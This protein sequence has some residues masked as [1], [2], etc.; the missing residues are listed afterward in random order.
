MPKASRSARARAAFPA[1][2]VMP[3]T[4][5]DIKVQAVRRPWRAKSCCTATTLI[6]AHEH[7][8]QLA[9]ERGL[10]FVHPF[11]DVDVIAGQGTIGMEILR[12]QHGDE[13]DAIFVPI[14][15]GGLIAR[16]CG[17]RQ[18]ALSDAS[19]SSASSP[20]TAAGMHESLRA[21]KR[22]TLDRVG[23]FADG[24]AV[25]RSAKSRFAWRSNS[26]TRSSW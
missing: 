1:V 9:R 3:H 11:D 18:G 23:M 2:I 24:V 8:A 12:Q 17:V 19:G 10:M 7:A 14:G 26:S 22:V 20:R 21:G 6:E 16:H 25:R 13:I 15:G 4:T 5:P